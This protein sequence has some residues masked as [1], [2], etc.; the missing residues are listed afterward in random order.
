MFQVQFQVRIEITLK[1][2]T[3]SLNCS[4]VA[5]NIMQHKLQ[6]VTF[7]AQFTQTGRQV[8]VGLNDSLSQ[9]FK[10]E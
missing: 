4:V 1:N 10:Y 9:E 3:S 6:T 5:V 2:A 7:L 8:S